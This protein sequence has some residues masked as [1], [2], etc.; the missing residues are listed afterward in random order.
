MEFVEEKDGRGL[1][2]EQGPFAEG[3]ALAIALQMAEVLGHIHERHIVHRDIKPENLL[4]TSDGTVKLCD[5]GLRRR[6]PSTRPPG[7]GHSA[8]SQQ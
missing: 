3:K 6:R 1:V 4:R 8:A 7:G 2:T 5:S